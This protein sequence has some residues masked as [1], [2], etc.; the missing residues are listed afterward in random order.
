VE[1]VTE[2]VKNFVVPGSSWFLML[3]ASICGVLLFGTPEMR[4]AGRGFLVALAAL[5]WV[6]SVPMFAAMLQRTLA[7]GRSGGSSIAVPLPIV[8]LGNGTDRFEAFGAGI[9]VPLAQTAMNTLFALDR[10]RRFP[11]SIV[12]VSGGTQPGNAGSPEAAIIAD[13]LRRNGVPGDRILLEDRSTTTREQ[14]VATS[15]ILAARGDHSCILVTSPQQ[16]WR[17]AEIFQ[18][19]GISVIR[20][21]AGAVLGS[22]AGGAHWWSPLIPSSQARTVSRDVL[23]EIIASP[24]YRIRGWVG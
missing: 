7:S 11:T 1:V 3:G 24:Y 2:F 19:A 8:I 18:G 23:Y 20:L 6:M 15:R 22:Q 16:M 17:A 13:E 14:A 9:D 21:P 5:Y 12:V 4:K 10:Y